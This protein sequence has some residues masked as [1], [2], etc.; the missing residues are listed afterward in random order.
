MPKTTEKAKYRV[1]IAA[2][3]KGMTTKAGVVKRKAVKPAVC[4]AAAQIW[5]GYRLASG[6][7]AM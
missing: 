4:S 2:F 1:I 6:A 3:D 7:M 5:R